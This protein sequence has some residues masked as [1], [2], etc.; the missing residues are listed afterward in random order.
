[1]VTRVSSAALLTVLL[2]ACCL[3]Q[4][5]AGWQILA[6][7]SVELPGATLYYEKALADQV[8]AFKTIY[9]QFRAERAQLQAECQA[10]LKQRD[11][12]VAE[13]DRIVGLAAND[14]QRAKQGEGLAWFVT[15]P[16]SMDLTKDARFVLLQKETTKNHLRKGGS[17]PGFTYDPATDTAAYRLE[18]DSS[19]GEGSG[20]SSRE[21]FLP[22][23][24]PES[25]EQE[26]RQSLSA[27][28]KATPTKAD[29]VG[30]AIHEIVEAT[31]FIRLKPKDPNFRWF[32]DGF[33]N[34]ITT[35]LLRTYVG[36]KAAKE[37]ADLYDPAPYADL[38]KELNLY[39]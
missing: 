31:I 19:G 16:S 32:S 24:G 5:K 21:I 35:R 11:E 30:G 9:G 18:F 3:G 10:L 2:S 39:Y 6:P 7:D 25:A 36:E 29:S 20:T 34:A 37:F 1:M 17:L 33:S 26:F 14:A 12:V 15:S 8:E 38:E 23:E 28:A 22:V 27:F 4:E 13:I